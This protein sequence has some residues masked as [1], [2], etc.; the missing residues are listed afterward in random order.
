MKGLKRNLQALF[1]CSI[2]LSNIANKAKHP[3]IAKLILLASTKLRTKDED[4]T[5]QTMSNK[6]KQ[7]APFA[8]SVPV[9]FEKN[10]AL[11]SNFQWQ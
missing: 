10:F 5:E 4:A 3:A 6:G 1:L 8:K 9:C 2:Y 7:A 11:G